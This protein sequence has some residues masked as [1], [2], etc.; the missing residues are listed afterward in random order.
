VP[1]RTTTI[2]FPPLHLPRLEGTLSVSQ[3]RSACDMFI[4]DMAKLASARHSPRSNWQCRG[5]CLRR[6]PLPSARLPVHRLEQCVPDM[7]CCAAVRH[8]EIN[9]GMRYS[10]ALPRE[11]RPLRNIVQ[12]A[13]DVHRGEHTPQ[14]PLCVVRRGICW[15]DSTAAD[16]AQPYD[17]SCELKHHSFPPCSTISTLEVL[18]REITVRKK[19]SFA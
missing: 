6:V 4:D 8:K 12:D 7:C 13:G 2:I 19:R 3:W 16:A 15:R 9:K 14:V 10:R 18:A 11:R 5:Y 17:S 1:D